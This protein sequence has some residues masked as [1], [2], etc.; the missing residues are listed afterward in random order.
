MKHYGVIGVSVTMRSGLIRLSDEQAAA[1]KHNLKK[2]GEGE[3][4][5]LAPIQF[6]RGEQFGYDGDLLKSLVCELKESHQPAAASL[7]AEPRGRG[8]G[9]NKRPAKPEEPP[10]ELEPVVAAAVT[11]PAVAEAAEEAAEIDPS[12]IL[13]DATASDEEP[14]EG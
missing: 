1:R 8:R 10:F 13:P 2:V 12:E 14:G 4:R 5:I 9:R 11:A 7:P 6:K 3:Y